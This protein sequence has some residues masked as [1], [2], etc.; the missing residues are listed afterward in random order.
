MAYYLMKTKRLAKEMALAGR[1]LEDKELASYIL[2]SLGEEYDSIVTSVT[3]RVEPIS[4]TELYTQLTAYE[5]LK[6]MH[7]GGSQSSVNADVKGGHGGHGGHFNNSG[8]GHFNNSCGR[9]GGGHGR[10]N[11]GGHGGRGGG[12]GGCNFQKCV[13][14]QICGI[15]GH[16]VGHCYKRFDA[17]YSGIPQ[18][19]TSAATTSSY[20]VDTNWYMTLELQIT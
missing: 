9:G 16:P 17:S 15:E 14:R 18:K 7:G 8:G 13:I 6:E 5:Q 1:K 19:S 12:G 20:G 10:G 2:T 3:T 11:K 4:I